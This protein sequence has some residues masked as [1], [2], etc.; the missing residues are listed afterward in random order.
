MKETLDVKVSIITVSLNSDKTIEQT[1]LSVLHQTYQNIEYLII[2]GGSTDGTI[3]II[4]KYADRIT[5]F[6]SEPDKGLYDAMNK[7]IKKAQ[8]E[9]I[10]I[11]NSDD[12]YEL[13]AVETAV[14][15]YSKNS[16]ADVIHGGLR[17]YEN[18]QYSSSYC[19]KIKELN[20]CM[21]PHP[22]C[23][24]SK[25]TYA[26]HGNYNVKY[27]IA[28][29]YDLVARIYTAKGKFVFINKIL[30]NLRMGGVSDIHKDNGMKE[31]NEI[32]NVYN[33]K[34]KISPFKI[35]KKKIKSIFFSNS[36]DNRSL[37]SRKIK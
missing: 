11:I 15:L 17:F 14:S 31:S 27:R 7:G 36:V 33:L 5:Y 16:N 20:L 28:A 2:D 25:K 21:I 23:F 6:F 4:Q 26:T 13:D 9:L 34:Y 19:P 32:K 30:A 1:I 35:I 29:D 12:W 37:L 3:E 8:G 22:A 18:E 24:I 10:G